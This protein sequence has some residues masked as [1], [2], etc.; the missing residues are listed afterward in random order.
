[1][2]ER[3][4]FVRLSFFTFFWIELNSSF[5]E[6]NHDKNYNLQIFNRFADAAAYVV[7]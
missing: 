6:F 1:M 2:V 7:V 3:Y 5:K 4:K